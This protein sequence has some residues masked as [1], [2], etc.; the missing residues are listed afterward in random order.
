MCG[1]SPSAWS[2]AGSVNGVFDVMAHIVKDA[3][4]ALEIATGRA[5]AS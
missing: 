2:V 1:A 4:C 5:W 3:R